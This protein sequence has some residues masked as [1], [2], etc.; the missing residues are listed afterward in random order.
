MPSLCKSY[1]IRF[2]RR[3]LVFRVTSSS[4]EILQ[5]LALMACDRSG[6]GGEDWRLSLSLAFYCKQSVSYLLIS[7]QCSLLADLSEAFYTD[8]WCRKH[9]PLQVIIA[10]CCWQ[11]YF[12][13]KLFNGACCLFC[14]NIWW[15]H[16][17]DKSDCVELPRE[18]WICWIGFMLFLSVHSWLYELPSVASG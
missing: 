1:I 4:P 14:R 12:R 2:Y 13:M 8:N 9:E 17:G 3:S 15:C 7:L 16:V 11:C 10:I 18:F 5:A 6:I